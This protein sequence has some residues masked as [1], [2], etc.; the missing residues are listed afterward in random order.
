MDGLRLRKLS[1]NKVVSANV[2]H[3]RVQVLALHFQSDLW[4]QVKIVDSHLLFPP[5]SY[6]VMTKR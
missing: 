4:S 6:D 3:E 1:E 2:R 5:S